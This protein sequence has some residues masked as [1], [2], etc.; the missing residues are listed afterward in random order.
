MKRAIATLTAAV[1]V[2]TAAVLTAATTTNAAPDQGRG[3]GAYAVSARVD[4]GV[5]TLGEGVVKVRG[6]VT[7]RAAGKKALLQHRQSGTSTWKIIDRA[8]IKRNGTYLLTDEP[9]AIGTQDYRV[10][11]LPSDGLRKGTSRILEVRVVDSATTTE[12]DVYT[13]QKLAQRRPGT[14]ENIAVSSTALIG[15]QPFAFSFQPFTRGAPSFVDYPLG[16]RCTELRTTYAM[17]DS[18]AADSSSRITLAVDGVIVVDQ[19]LVKGQ[20]VASTTDLT[21][22]TQLRYD[23]YSNASPASYPVVVTPEVL[24]AK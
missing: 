14:S 7:P 6:T 3:P 16:G 4:A 21:G 13:W 15:A 20:V 19:A 2:A 11:K 9:S 1:V 17:H 8:R 18:A 12:D 5:V 10:V 24:C 23:L 22:A